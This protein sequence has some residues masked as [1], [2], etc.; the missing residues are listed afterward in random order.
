MGIVIRQ[1]WLDEANLD[2]P[3]TYDDL[4]EALVAFK[5]NNNATMWVNQSGLLAFDVLNAGYD[6]AAYSEGFMGFYPFRVV[7]GTV[8]FCWETD[9]FR[10]FL[11][12][13]STW[14]SEGLIYP[15]FATSG[16]TLGVDGSNAFDDFL[17]GKIGVALAAMNDL[18]NFPLNA[19]EGQES[20][21]LAAMGTPLLNENDTDHIR[22]K[23]P[24]V[25]VKWSISTSCDE[26]LIDTAV[27]FMDFLY[28]DV[29]SQLASYGVEGVTYTVS[30]GE[31]VFTDL[32]LNNE[33]GLAFSTVMSIYALDEAPGLIDCD[34][35]SQV[36]SEAAF[37]AAK[38][39]GN[40]DAAHAYPLSCSLNTSES[41]TFNSIYSEIETYGLEHITGFIV[42]NFSVENDWDSFVSTMQSMGSAQLTAL[43]QAAYDRY[44]G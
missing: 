34:R 28:S 35:E 23:M 13:M 42:G 10:D 8:D 22:F 44:I 3:V 9:E 30:G 12:M 25:S 21:K 17:N 6:I 4:H 14:Y 18:E 40:G 31:P 15:D 24:A 2:V 38:L 32:V 16:S 7:D 11:T 1:D 20:M 33:D 41:E 19:G 5:T 43:K 26:A 37:Q 39:W 29:G 27:K 36:Y